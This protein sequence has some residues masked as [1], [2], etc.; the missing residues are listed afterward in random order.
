MNYMGGKYKL[1][2]DILPSFPNCDS[3][4]DLFADGMNVSVN[5]NANNIYANDRI[6]ELIE[7]YEYFQKTGIDDII[8]GVNEMIHRYSLSKQ[9]VEGY[10]KLRADYNANRS[11]LQLFVLTCYS[12]NHQIRFNHSSQ[13]NVPFA[14]ERGNFNTS[15]K[16]N[17]IQFVTA[18]QEKHIILSSTD[19]RDF[20]FDRLKSGDMVYCDPPYLITTASYNDGNRGHGGWGVEED[21]DLLHL[22]DELNAK[23]IRFALSNVF[24]HKSKAN[25]TLIKWSERYHVT[26][27]DKTYSNCNYHLKDKKAKTVE[28]LITNEK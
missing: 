18:L 2:Q 8:A 14:K 5:V 16:K 25:E 19:F 7:L 26:Y 20:P 4:V 9:N 22:L 27:L 28:V 6:G 15:I 10:N 17:L 24:Y 12:F 11:P 13:F 3:F 1:L 21:R 23:N